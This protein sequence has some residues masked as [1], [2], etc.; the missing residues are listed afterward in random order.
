MLS[1]Q[2]EV[3]MPGNV[4]AWEPTNMYYGC[5]PMAATDPSGTY[6]YYC[7]GAP[8]PG[9]CA[10]GAGGSG[11]AGNS[12]GVG[13]GGSSPACDPSQCPTPDPSTEP[14]CCTQNQCG[15]MFAGMCLAGLGTGGAGGGG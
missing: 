14:A 1:V 6:P 13:A 2:S 4:C 9:A 8:V 7:N 12:G 5:Q 3:C 11:A 15:I 10:A